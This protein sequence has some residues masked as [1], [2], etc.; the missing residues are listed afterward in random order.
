MNIVRKFLYQNQP[1]NTNNALEKNNSP[2]NNK[3]VLNEIH[4]E[5]NNIRT[6]GHTISLLVQIGELLF[7]TALVASA[8]ITAGASIF[9]LLLN[10]ATFT[11]IGA[12]ALILYYSWSIH[13]IKQENKQIDQ[14]IAKELNSNE[15]SQDETT[16]K[17]WQEEKKASEANWL[18]QKNSQKI[19]PENGQFEKEDPS[20]NLSQSGPD[21]KTKFDEP[22]GEAAIS[23][24]NPHL[25]AYQQKNPSGESNIIP[26]IPL[27]NFIKVGST[28][29]S[30]A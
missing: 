26:T 11:V 1:P 25:A 21:Q 5:V 17:D 27:L 8:T 28:I 14:E 15:S 3:L 13:K 30:A 18:D 19:G 9:T 2:K 12:I 4:K 29:P 10:S 6:E 16:D 23:K 20:S 24:S 7:G 22:M